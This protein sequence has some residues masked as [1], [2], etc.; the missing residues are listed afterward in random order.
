VIR[1]GC[2]KQFDDSL[3]GLVG[4]VIGGFQ[5]AVGAVRRIGL[6]V[7]AAVGE[8]TAEPLVEEQEQQGDLDAFG[9]EL[10]G[11]ARAVAFQESVAFELAE[12]VAELV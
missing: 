8:R 10:I 12:V 5:L 1:S 6:V 2:G 3:N 4:F 9:G 11:V 7:E